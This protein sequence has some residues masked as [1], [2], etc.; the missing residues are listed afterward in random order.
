MWYM[1]RARQEWGTERGIATWILDHPTCLR[2]F[3][4]HLCSNNV[5]G[6]PSLMD[7]S[8]PV[9]GHHT[10]YYPAYRSVLLYPLIDIAQC[11]SSRLLV[12]PPWNQESEWAYHD[13]KQQLTHSA[14][15]ITLVLDGQAAEV[16]VSSSI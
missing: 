10:L 15:H 13:C 12:L 2:Y 11:H 1:E 7:T 3:P 8:L 4:A 14:L 5:N 16:S 9:M 6:S